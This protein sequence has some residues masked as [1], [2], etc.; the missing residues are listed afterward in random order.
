MKL[1]FAP[2]IAILIAIATSLQA[3]PTSIED[4]YDPALKP[5]YHGVASGDPL[6]D[7]FIIWTRY[8]P[9]QNQKLVP[10]KWEVA[11]DP[12][13]QNVVAKGTAFATESSD[14]TVKVDVRGLQS[15]KTYYYQFRKGNEFSLVGKAKTAPTA[16]VESI[17]FAVV[18]CSNYEWGYFSGYGKIAERTDLDAVIHLGD[19]TYEYAD[20]ASYSSPQIRDERVVFPA[21]ETI[22]LDDYRARYA[23][24]RLDPNL[25]RAHQQHP[26]IVVWDDHES[27]ND[28]WKGGAENHQPDE[29]DWETRKAVAKQAYFEWQPI[30]E[31][32]GEIYR[33]LSYGPLLDL[34]MLDTR[35]AGRDQQPIFPLDNPELGLLQALDPTR[36]ML[37]AEQK[38]WLIEELDNSTAQWKVIGNQVIF[39][40]FNIGFAGPIQGTTYAGLEVL[41]LDIWDG[42]RAERSELIDL[43]A[44]I[45]DIVII[46]G[47]FHSSF[48]WEVVDF[49]ADFPFSL[50]AY[51]P[52]TGAGA[53][54]VEFATP[55]ISAAN[56][57]ENL[58]DMGSPPGTSDFFEFIINKPIDAAGNFNPAGFN[59]NPHMAY[60]DLD[61]HGYM[62]LTVTESSVQAD[63]FYLADILVAETM[64]AWGAGL[65]AASGNPDLNFA[66][67]AAAPKLI[68]DQP[69]PAQ[70]I[71]TKGRGKTKG[72]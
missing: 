18:S 62:V 36:S 30:R 11:A 15:G 9:E 71:K 4:L 31:E 35:L 33:T 13:M 54:A 64:E 67:T 72:K 46:T 70:V 63:Y 65:F 16:G 59:F 55:S 21:G 60:A 56:F 52:A 10:V 37:G 51:D 6:E 68:Q 26:F 23:T 7:G 53:V 1:S 41:F 22:S 45:D 38:A 50:P 34:I 58:D 49:P 47:D 5:F 61:Q 29:G 39:S 2:T 69:A 17:K 24:Y 14:F 57:D 32:N 27:A 44:G 66:A 43:F 20:N 3:Q 28:A 40:E 8:T 19:Y 12:M 48:A 25:R 42:Y